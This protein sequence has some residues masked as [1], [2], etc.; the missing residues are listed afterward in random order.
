MTDSAIDDLVV[1]LACWRSDQDHIFTL[2]A[3]RPA[4]LLFGLHYLHA[5]FSYLFLHSCAAIQEPGLINTFRCFL[6]GISSLKHLR[7]ST[8]REEKN[9]GAVWNFGRPIKCCRYGF[10]VISSASSRSEKP[11]C[12]WM[13]K[14]PGA[15]LRGFADIPVLLGHFTELSA[16][17]LL[18]YNIFG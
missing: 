9:S 15:V 14:E 12:F 4:L 7:N 6:L 17:L 5:Q 11:S 8:I 13:S 3:Q 1:W 10:F 2:Q 16:F 18:Y